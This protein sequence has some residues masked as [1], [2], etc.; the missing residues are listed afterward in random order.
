VMVVMRSPLLGFCGSF[1]DQM[2][3]PVLIMAPPPIL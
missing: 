1:L 3:C 2:L